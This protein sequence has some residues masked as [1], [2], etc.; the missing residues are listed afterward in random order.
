MPVTR[1]ESNVPTRRALTR[2]QLLVAA[3]IVVA[4]VAIGVYELAF[5]PSPQNNTTTTVTTTVTTTTTTT[6]TTSPTTTTTTT[7][8]TTTPTSQTIKVTMPVGYPLGTNVS[9]SKTLQAGE[10]VNGT[11]QLTGASQPRDNIATFYFR[12]YAPN[13]SMVYDWTGNWMNNNL[14]YFSF[15]AASVGSY[16]IVVTHFSQYPKDLTIQISAPGWA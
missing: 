5:I 15:T 8:Q 1:A 14:Q 2:I 16:R 4:V 6:S 7:T 13:G 3:V 12:I 11:V 9:Y 10:L